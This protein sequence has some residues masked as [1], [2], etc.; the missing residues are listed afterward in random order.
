MLTLAQHHVPETA[1]L[2]LAGGSPPQGGI[3]GTCRRVFSRMAALGLTRGFSLGA[4]LH[5]GAVAALPGPAQGSS[6]STGSHY[7]ASFSRFS[8]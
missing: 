6:H 2:G 4:A 7:A 3:S 5:N 1:A 8:T